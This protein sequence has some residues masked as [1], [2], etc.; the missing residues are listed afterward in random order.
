MSVNTV[1]N[2]N[3]P[4]L[5]VYSDY[6]TA[7]WNVLIQQTHIDRLKK[8]NYCIEIPLALFASSAVGGL[9]FWGTFTGGILWNFLGVCAA[10]MAVIKPFLKLPERIEQ[11]GKMLADYCS[12]ENDL[13]IITKLIYQDRKYDEKLRRRYLRALEKKGKIRDKYVGTSYMKN[14]EK[15]V[16][17]CRERIDKRLPPSTFYFPEE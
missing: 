3:H 4:V 15:I 14:S 2:P 9:A 17:R 6:K 13:E 1:R 11:R 5:A 12:I 10:I 7:A 8:I 16:N